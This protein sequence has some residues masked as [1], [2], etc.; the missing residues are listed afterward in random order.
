VQTYE[1]LCGKKN[2]LNTKEHKGKHKVT[3]R[4]KEI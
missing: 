4:E 1:I 3:L 2:P